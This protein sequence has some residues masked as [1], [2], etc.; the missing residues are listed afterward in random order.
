MLST[1]LAVLLLDY[2][3]KC[4]ILLLEKFLFYGTKIAMLFIAQRLLRENAYQVNNQNNFSEIFPAEML[5]KVNAIGC[6]SGMT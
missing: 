5:A 4:N 3:L 1:T 6:R 2:G